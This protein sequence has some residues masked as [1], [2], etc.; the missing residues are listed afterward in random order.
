MHVRC[1]HSL[2]LTL[3]YWE[4]VEPLLYCHE[5]ELCFNLREAVAIEVI[6]REEE[7]CV[8]SLTNA[9]F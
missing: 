6:F 9:C 4:T 1:T 2:T 7:I 8:D 5:W 3:D